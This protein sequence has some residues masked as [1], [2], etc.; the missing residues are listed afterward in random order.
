MTYK[1]AGGFTV[2]VYNE[3]T[4]NKIDSICKNYGVTYFNTGCI[5]DFMDI[6]AQ[7]KYHETVKPYLIKRNGK[8][9]EQK[10]K[11]EIEKIKN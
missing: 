3:E 7:E 6:K 5:I 9:W 4:V 1:F 11:S 8:N 10:M 2:P